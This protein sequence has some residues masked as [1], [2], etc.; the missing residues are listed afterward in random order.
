[1]EEWML[2]VWALKP[3]S[4]W[5]GGQIDLWIYCLALFEHHAKFRRARGNCFSMEI[6]VV[7]NIW[8]P[9]A[10]FQGWDTLKFIAC[11]RNVTVQK[12]A[13]W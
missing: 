12:L 8:A 10:S 13:P 9:G 11:H 2:I 7:A 5:M 1:M 3:Q 6:R 4:L